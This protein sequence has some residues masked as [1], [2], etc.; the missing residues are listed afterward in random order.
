[1]ALIRI[2]LAEQ[3]APNRG[4]YEIY[5]EGKPTGEIIG[6]TGIRKFLTPEQYANFLNGDDIFL[7]P[8]E[9]FRTRN[10]KQ[11]RRFNGKSSKL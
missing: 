5:R 7:V 10:H 8:G 2:Y 9:K 4:K 1:M 6:V 3:I 11:K